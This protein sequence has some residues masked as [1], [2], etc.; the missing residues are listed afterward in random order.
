TSRGDRTLRGDE[1][2]L[3]REA[4]DTMI[5]GLLIHLEDELDQQVD[6]PISTEGMVCESGVALY[7]VCSFTQRIG[8][9]HEVATHLLTETV[10]AVPLSAA[11]E[12]TIAAIFVDIRDHV[13]IEI[14][15]PEEQAGHATLDR[16]GWRHLVASAYRSLAER[17]DVPVS[18]VPIHD[19][20]E[21]DESVMELP[22]ENS[23]DI[24]EWEDVVEYLADAI[25]WDRDFELSESFYDLDPGVSSQRRRLM[26]ID[27]DYFTRVAPDPRPDQ[28]FG[29]VSKTRD[30]VRAKPR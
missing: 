30:I 15:F 9:L 26:G 7:D 19:G 24:G 13:A 5:D 27:N 25:L 23:S 6:H 11:L 28:V 8:L 16:P 20:L 12:A 22:E 18:A 29:L 17:D 21:D 1:A 3:V 10:Q 4:I 14:N 2:T